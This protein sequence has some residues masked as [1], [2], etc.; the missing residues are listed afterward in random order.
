MDIQLYVCYNTKMKT[1]NTLVGKKRKKLIQKVNNPYKKTFI[2]P[3]LLKFTRE[4]NDKEVEEWKK[5]D[6]LELKR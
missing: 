1:G 4:F 3:M 2:S 6:A 5:E